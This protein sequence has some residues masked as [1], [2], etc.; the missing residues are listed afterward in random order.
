MAETKSRR[1]QNDTRLP[2]DLADGDEDLR[3]TDEFGRPISGLA[4]LYISGPLGG[5]VGGCVLLQSVNAKT[6][7]IIDTAPGEAPGDHCLNFVG[8]QKFR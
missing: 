7:A 8:G 6:G 1:D 5:G 3:D 2:P 4:L